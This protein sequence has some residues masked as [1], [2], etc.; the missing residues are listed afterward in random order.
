ML[1]CHSSKFSVTVF[2]TSTFL[3]KRPFRT[4][5]F[6]FAWVVESPRMQKIYWF[7]L[8][9]YKWHIFRRRQSFRSYN[10][11]YEKWKR[12][13]ALNN[14]NVF[15]SMEWS[16]M[17]VWRN[18]GGPCRTNIWASFSNKG[19]TF[20]QGRFHVSATNKFFRVRPPSGIAFGASP[21]QLL[22]ITFSWYGNENI[23]GFCWFLYH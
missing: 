21:A 20:L 19:A 13:L 10:M 5:V 23:S 17:A 1:W 9:I 22:E 15:V 6:C 4:R 12:S 16:R 11:V 14:R 8:G 2:F 3:T 7:D 18:A